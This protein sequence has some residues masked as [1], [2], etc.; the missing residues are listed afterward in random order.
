MTGVSSRPALKLIRFDPSSLLGSL[1]YVL[2]NAK[3][4]PAVMSHEL[5]R[6]APSASKVLCR[7]DY[8]SLSSRRSW[9]FVTR[10]NASASVGIVP[11]TDEGRV[12]LVE[13]HREPVGRSVIELPSGLAGDVSGAESESRVEAAQ[14]ELYEE[15]GYVASCWTDLNSGYSSPGLTD[16]WIALFLA[17]GLEKRGPGGGDDSE[18]IVVHEVLLDDI[19]GWLRRHDYCTD[20]K[21]MAGL[22]AAQVCLRE[23]E[24]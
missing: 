1:E 11:L 15:T 4:R 6:D 13:Q 23:R 3:R 8:L 19:A 16:E 7:G 12:V 24:C 2:L 17:Q 21:L 9:E 20:L 5:N 18:S 22:Y 10:H 14:R